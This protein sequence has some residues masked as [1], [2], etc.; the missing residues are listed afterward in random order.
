M[1]CNDFHILDNQVELRKGKKRVVFYISH[2]K[3]QIGSYVRKQSS[4]YNVGHEEFTRTEI[5]NI[6]NRL[7]SLFE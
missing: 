2:L 5:K 1:D 4:N 7:N 6:Q 3:N